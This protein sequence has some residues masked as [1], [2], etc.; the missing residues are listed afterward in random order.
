MEPKQVVVTAGEQAPLDRSILTTPEGKEDLQVVTMTWWKQ[1][2]IRTARTYLQ[3]LVGFLVAAGSGAAGALG[4]QLPV[5]DF[6]DLLLTSASLAVAPA[7]IALL[8]NAVEILGK[9]DSPG[10]RA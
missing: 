2:A 3:G 6:A 8:Q 7:V 4:I 9:L 1:A 10:T 5:H